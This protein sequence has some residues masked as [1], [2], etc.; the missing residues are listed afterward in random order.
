MNKKLPASH[1]VL[2]VFN[3]LAYV[4]DCIECVLQH[5]DAPYELYIVDD[6]SDS[7]TASFLEERAQEFP[8]ISLHRNQMNLGFLRSCKRVS[9]T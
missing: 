1:I 7:V 8:H 3:A 9:E 6:C 4:R 5:T 2:P